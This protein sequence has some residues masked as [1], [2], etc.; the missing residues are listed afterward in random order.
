[1]DNYLQPPVNTGQEFIARKFKLQ[2]T[3]FLFQNI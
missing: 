1:M 2:K 3:S